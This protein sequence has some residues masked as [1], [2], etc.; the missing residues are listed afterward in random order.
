[1]FSITKLT[2]FLAVAASMVAGQSC[3]QGAEQIGR[4]API[5]LAANGTTVVQEVIKQDAASYISLHFDAL[6]LPHGSKLTLSA[7]DGSSR[8]EYTGRRSDFYAEYIPGD[9]VVLTYTPPRED[10]GFLEGASA[11]T[12]DRFAYGVPVKTPE[13]VCGTDDTKAVVCVKNSLPTQYNKAQA[14]ARL[15]I[16]GTSLCT[17]WLI[18]SE[19][20]L[21]T[22]NHC[23]GNAAAAK[24]V[25][26]EFGAECSSCTDPNN[27]KQLGCKGTIVATSA[28]FIR[29]S[30]T[31][32]YTL[33]KLNLKSG[34]SLAKYGYL[35]ARASGPRLN[36]EIYIPQHPA[37]KPTRIGYLLDDGS[38]G[39]I[40]TLSVDKCVKNEVGYMVDTEGGS[41]GSPVL[42]PVDHAVV[43][44]HNC[45][46]C[47]N[48]GIKIS[49]IVK[50]LKSANQLPPKATI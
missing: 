46:G 1:M 21:I 12:I 18:G 34:V 9:S 14:V 25:Q 38:A 26:F 50:D 41:S 47:L 6:D 8:V 10:I 37:G 36:E 35:Q 11:Y 30:T 48:G 7:P 29:T 17:G 15:L 27:T 44:L 43:A 31:L 24:D 40:E 45:G 28:T 2:A 33:V 13:A 49:D 22:N 42:S 20:H 39:T 4:T 19:G 23:I 5:A 32:D 3:F 16:G